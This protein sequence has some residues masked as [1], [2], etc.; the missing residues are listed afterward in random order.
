MLHRMSD[1][2]AKQRHQVLEQHAGAALTPLRNAS[3]LVGRWEMRFGGP[4][5]SD[6]VQWVYDFKR[7]GQLVIGDDSGGKWQLHN[8]GLL[9]LWFPYEADPAF[10]LEAGLTEES[11]LAFSTNDGRVVL[12]NDDT[13]VVELLIRILT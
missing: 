5:G 4:L 12:S 11:R 1:D 2:Y 10:D 9:S 13:S 6:A 8:D 7:D 3:A